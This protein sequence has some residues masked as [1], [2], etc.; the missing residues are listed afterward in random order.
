MIVQEIDC[1]ILLIFIEVI[2]L[3][4]FHVTIKC[5]KDI[6]MMPQEI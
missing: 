1:T 4:L 3:Y 6:P 5:T 2:N